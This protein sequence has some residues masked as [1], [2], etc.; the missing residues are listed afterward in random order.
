MSI[1][2]SWHVGLELVL[3][4]VVQV[5]GAGLAVPVDAV[6]VDSRECIRRRLAGLRRGARARRDGL[7]GVEQ[8]AAATRVNV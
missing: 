2:R 1:L 7:V 5:E 8:S 4:L 3:E 6:V